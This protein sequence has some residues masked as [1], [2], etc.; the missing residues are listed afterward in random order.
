MI[1]S[2]GN[3][4][5][6]LVALPYAAVNAGAQQ[7]IKRAPELPKYVTKLVVNNWLDRLKK[8]KK[9]NKKILNNTNKLWKIIKLIKS[10][11]YI[12]ILLKRTTSKIT[13]QE[14]GFSKFL[15]Q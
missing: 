13:S 4:G 7:L 15:G 1:Q 5:E 9:K 8:L 6:L 11:E 14:G 12:G 10:L 3:L 2:G